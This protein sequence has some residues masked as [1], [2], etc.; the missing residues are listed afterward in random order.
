MFNRPAFPT[1]EF[2]DEHLVGCVPG[3]T[4]RTYVAAAVCSSLLASQQLQL[5]DNSARRAEFLRTLSEYAVEAADA[6]LI[7]LAA[8]KP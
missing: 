8:T 3:M 7:A 5:P 4:Q 6:L 2:Y 1:Q